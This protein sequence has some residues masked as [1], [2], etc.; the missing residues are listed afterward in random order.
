M[1]FLPGANDF[2]QTSLLEVTDGDTAA[3]TLH[4]QLLSELEGVAASAKIM[5]SEEEIKRRRDEANRKILEAEL[6]KQVRETQKPAAPAGAITNETLQKARIDGY[7]PVGTQRIN[8]N[9]KLSIIGGKVTVDEKGENYIIHAKD[10]PPP[11]TP[12][13]AAAISTSLI[14][15]AQ[16]GPQEFSVRSEMAR[17]RKLSGDELAEGVES[18]LLTFSTKISERRA[19]IDQQAKLQSGLNEAEAALALLQNDQYTTMTSIGREKLRTA[20]QRVTAAAATHQRLLQSMANSDS[21]LQELGTGAKLIEKMEMN[22]AAREQRT[23]DKNEARI[24][25]E[26]E[27]LNAMPEYMHKNYQFAIGSNETDPKKLRAE[28]KYVLTTLRKDPEFRKIVD[29]TPETIGLRLTDKSAR[30]REA[31]FKI[32]AGYDKD[33]FADLRGSDASSTPTLN[34]MKIRKIVE[35]PFILAIQ[36]EVDQNIRAELTAIK[37]MGGQ[38]TT[39]EIEEKRET[40]LNT[41]FRQYVQKS[42]VNKVSDA[43]SWRTPQTLVGTP[44]GDT[45]NQIKATRTKGD[46]P[47]DLVVET[48]IK[49]KHAKQDG[50]EM[51]PNE[52]REILN[53]AIRGVI[54][55]YENNWIEPNLIALQSQWIQRIANLANRMIV[56]QN[57]LMGLPNSTEG[58]DFTETPGGAAVYTDA[59]A[60]RIGTGG[61]R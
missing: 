28:K 45:I 21:V 29:T 52:K 40:L 17:L 31:A 43:G 4:A 16:G 25:A 9:A 53:V 14:K 5:H 18:A 55:Q 10:L 54:S 34:E 13:N 51:T 32:L 57:I 39:K 15:Q 56:R 61:T 1:N 42:Y 59:M 19:F 38:G 60:R 44:L 35:D 48:F 7:R 20:Q 11:E 27:E 50:T 47:F 6:E 46:A 2:V 33:R 23:A 26:D 30:V 41:A 36:P 58:F 37:R 49:S 12:P 3:K 22:R 8:P 24:A